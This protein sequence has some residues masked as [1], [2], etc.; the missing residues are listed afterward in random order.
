MPKAKHFIINPNRAKL[1]SQHIHAGGGGSYRTP[2]LISGHSGH[3]RTN[4]KIKRSC[5]ARKQTLNSFLTEPPKTVVHINTSG[6][7]I[8]Y[9]INFK[10]YEKAR[11]F[12]FHKI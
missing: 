12:I 2:F 9:S 3:K 7:C 10:F 5:F 11:P 4:Q 6:R 1:F 8:F